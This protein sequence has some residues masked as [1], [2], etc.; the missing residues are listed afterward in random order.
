MKKFFYS[1][2]VSFILFI[3][4]LS[5]TF[6]YWSIPMIILYSIFYIFYYEKAKNW[7]KFK[8]SQKL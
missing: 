1:N 4:M 2:W 6:M 3:T 7:R 5:L 8:K